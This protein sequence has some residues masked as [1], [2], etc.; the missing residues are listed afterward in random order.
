MDK[1]KGFGLIEIIVVIAIIAVL[2]GIVI[3]RQTENGQKPITQYTQDAKE[4][5]VKTTLGSI[6]AAFNVKLAEAGT[7]S[8][9][10]SSPP[11]Y[12]NYS[13]LKNIS[14][15]LKGMGYNF[16][17]E[18]SGENANCSGTS[19]KWYAVA[20]N[21]TDACFCTDSTS[22][23]AVVLGNYNQFLDSQNGSGLRNCAC[24]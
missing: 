2:A 18:E 24:R 5:S 8:G 11:D 1:Q 19:S 12:P 9:I 22:G 7:I 6:G 16:T 4:V 20:C 21:I 23:S 14:S 17:C 3:S 10:C 13:F 15:S